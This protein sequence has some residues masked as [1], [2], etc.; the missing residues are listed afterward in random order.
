MA[1]AG[2]SLL[3]TA[4]GLIIVGLIVLPLMHMHKINMAK[5]A[6]LGTS[7]NISK[8][9]D[10]I[11][12]YYVS[13]NGAYPCPADLSLK[14][15]D[16][17]Y[18][19]A[20]TCDLTSIELCSNATWFSTGGG[21]CKT[22]DTADAVIIGGVP[23]AS[24]RM[25]QED[26]YDF[27]KNK[28]IYAVT[29][30]QT[31]VTSYSTNNGSVRVRY[32]DSSGTPALSSVQYDIFI[33]STGESGVGGYTKNGFPLVACG[34]DLERNEFE[35]CDF[36]D[37]FFALDFGI[38]G[39]KVSAYSTVLNGSTPEPFFDDITGMQQYM[40]TNTWFQH[41]DNPLYTDIDFVLTKATKVGI[42]TSEPNSPHMG[43]TL[44][45]D[46]DVRADVSASPN[47]GHLES[48]SVCAEND[49]D[50][51]DPEIITGAENRMNCF[52]ST[53][54]V[55]DPSVVRAVKRIADT[56]VGCSSGV[57]ATGGTIDGGETL[58]VDTSKFNNVPCPSG[59]IANGIDASGN[60]LCISLS[61]GP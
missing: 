1:Q 3:E 27:W 26:S 56:A 6:F 2:L 60:L 19:F 47:G 20:K 40:Q 51:F 25:P 5:K 18:G 48:D 34:T 17:G 33:F 23:F 21:I 12:Q 58:K 28:Y 38:G 43:S 39:V 29:F 9:I 16:T 32:M 30:R 54:Y 41:E 7:G 13:G 45:V 57:G 46:G 53:A 24:L 14:E 42:G 37:T 11:N 50:C 15:G 49:A 10:G 61:L 59:Q 52:S 4:I 31:D 22:S 8:I 36:D 44:T 35:N 55:S